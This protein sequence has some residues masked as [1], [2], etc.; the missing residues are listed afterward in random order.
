MNALPSFSVIKH[1]NVQYPPGNYGPQFAT[2]WYKELVWKL[3]SSPDPTLREVGTGGARDNLETTLAKMKLH[4]ISQLSNGS[5][6]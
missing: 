5:K 4:A 3:V 1:L 2:E 6:F